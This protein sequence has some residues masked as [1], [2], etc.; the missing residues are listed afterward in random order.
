VAALAEKVAAALGWTEA[1]VADVREAALLHDVG[2]IGLDDRILDEPGPLAPGDRA[3]VEAHAELG[4]RIA[5]GSLGQAQLA[6]VRGHHERWD[7]AGYPDG[8]AGDA[9]PQGAQVIAVAEAWDAMT[10]ERPYAAARSR[11]DAL[12]EIRHEAGRQFAPGVAA[13]LEAVILAG[14]A[15]GRPEGA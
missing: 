2:K 4:E 9:I 10:S 5:A 3:R 11:D 6:W 7:G 12:E 14:D 8:L 13:A 15:I 1:G